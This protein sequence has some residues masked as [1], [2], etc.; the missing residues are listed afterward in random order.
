MLVHLIKSPVIDSR[1][2][3]VS[4]NGR[5]MAIAVLI[6]PVQYDALFFP[7]P[8]SITT[9]VSLYRRCYPVITT[10]PTTITISSRIG[11]AACDFFVFR[12]S[13]NK[14]KKQN[15]R[16]AKKQKSARKWR[17]IDWFWM[18]ASLI[19]VCHHFL[20]HGNSGQ[21]QCQQLVHN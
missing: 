4:S 6:K 9:M 21:W 19:I 10:T 12:Q 14:T 15:K 16:K 8:L 5:S 20:H 2:E 18:L 7:N 17:V 11:D 13:A 3:R 1:I